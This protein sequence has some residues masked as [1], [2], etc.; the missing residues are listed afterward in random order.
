MKKYTIIFTMCICF[1]V[2]LSSCNNTYIS[3]E[4]RNDETVLSVGGELNSSNEGKKHVDMF[5]AL[6][7][8]FLSWCQQVGY[9]PSTVDLNQMQENYV[10]L[11]G[12]TEDGNNIA[13]MD[14]YGIPDEAYTTYWK[15]K[16]TLASGDAKAAE[17]FSEEFKIEMNYDAWF[18]KETIPADRSEFINPSYK[19]EDPVS[20]FIRCSTDKYH[21]DRY[22]TINGFLIEYVGEDN[23][24]VFKEKY[25]GTEEFNILNFI[26][27]F[28]I[29]Q[30]EFD[31]IYNSKDYHSLSVP[32][33]S[34][35][36]YGS[37]ELQD[38]YFVRHTITDLTYSS[39]IISE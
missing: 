2:L 28:S 9:V 10:V 14:Y 38:L 16:Q 27:Y 26:K 11:F 24:D 34:E 15:N 36:I 18:S 39:K 12:G 33:K 29:S 7:F 20:V 6:D 8:L 31:S 35:Y 1:T 25:A 37:K 23:F 22:Y 5:Y 17:T 4:T 21:T 32:Y 30:E 19:Y 13:F 3:D